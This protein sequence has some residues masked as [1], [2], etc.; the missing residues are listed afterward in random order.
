MNV[1]LTWG[2][3]AQA[4]VLAIAG[5][6]LFTVAA[7]ARQADP[8]PG[9][10]GMMPRPFAQ[11]NLTAEQRQQVNKVLQE[12]RMAGEDERAELRKAHEELRAAIFGTSTDQGQ[13]DAIVSRIAQLEADALRARVATQ[14]KIASILTAEQ[15]AQLAKMEPPR[16]RR[17]VRRPAGPGR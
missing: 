15:K 5:V 9:R 10:R 4:F 2:R 13:V 17:G 16:G 6:A 11:L 8:A 12:Q 3:Q 1:R 7:S 14:M